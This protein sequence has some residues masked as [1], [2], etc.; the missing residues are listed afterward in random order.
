L[1]KAD[2]VRQ[3]RGTAKPAGARPPRLNHALYAQWVEGMK[4]KRRGIRIKGTRGH[5]VVAKAL[6]R[7]ASWLRQTQEFPIRVPVYLSPLE[8]VRALDGR[9]CS[10]S[11][12]APWDRNVEPYIR[13]ATGD[14]RELHEEMG[15]DNALASFIMSLAHEVVH[16]QQWVQTG[17]VQER[18]VARRA[19]GMLRRYESTVSRP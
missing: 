3:A 7:F 2:G 1:L 15:R 11:F 10:A 13:I 12:F 5:P 14:Y 6:V 16:Y 18:G 8:K 9:L 19:E 17:A 4:S